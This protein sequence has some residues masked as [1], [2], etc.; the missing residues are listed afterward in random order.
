MTRVLVVE[1]EVLIAGDIQETLVR[2]GYDVPITVSTGQRALLAMTELQPN[3]ILMDIKLRGEMDGVD[4]A[5]E[6]RRQVDVPIVYLTSHSD[7][8]TLTRAKATGP[9]GYL[10]K[11]F[12]ERELRTAIEV[13]LHRHHLE[14]KLAEREHWF[15]TTLRS[16]GDAVVATDPSERITFVN[17]VAGTLTGWGDDAIGKPFVEVFDVVDRAGHP[18]PSMAGLALAEAKSVDLP[19]HSCLRN[20]SGAQIAIDD[21]ASPIVDDR[22]TIL[23]SVVVFRDVTARRAL[24]ERVGLAERMASLGTLAAGVAHEINNPLSFVTVNVDLSLDVI[25]QSLARLE[26]GAAH[27]QA[28]LEELRQSLFDARAGAERI[29]LIVKGLMGVVRGGRGPG[30]PVDLDHAIVDAIK[31]TDHVIGHQ[32]RVRH[33]RAPL[34]LVVGDGHA[35]SQVVSNLLLNAA[36]AIDDA[37]TATREIVVSTM[38]NDDGQAVVEVRDTGPGIAA[39][40]LPRLFDPFFTTKAPGK[41]TGLGLAICHTI[42]ADAGGTLTASSPPGG[43]AVFRLTLPPAQPVVTRAASSVVATAMAPP[44]AR[45]LVV[46]DDALVASVVQRLLKHEHDVTVLLSS[47]AALERL[48]SDGAFDIVL[49]DVLMPGLSGLE[50]AQRVQAFNPTLA[51]RFVFMTGGA[52]QPATNGP[53]DTTPNERI[54]KPFAATALRELV[55]RFARARDEQVA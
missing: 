19:E 39:H 46:D 41:G 21:V 48:A 14:L 22:G 45:V 28:P 44:R 3:L 13:A 55:N 18:I 30:I 38:T 53:F 36:Q 16:V 34:P 52:I 35:F 8:D 32:A 24:E 31:M 1:D 26:P 23:G 20:R 4:T 2:L 27:L 17:T 33:L 29:R 43:G 49:C 40:V 51:R 10:L 42:V 47:E 25:A 12:T 11:P 54:E 50:L 7:E 5:A 37:S 15:S 6:I 9:H